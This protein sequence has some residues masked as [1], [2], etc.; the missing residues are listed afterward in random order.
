MCPPCAH[1]CVILGSIPVVTMKGIVLPGE[2]TSIPL[3]CWS[4]PVR[5]IHVAQPPSAVEAVLVDPK[6]ICIKDFHS[7]ASCAKAMEPEGRPWYKGKASTAPRRFLD[8]GGQRGHRKGGDRVYS[9]RQGR[10]EKSEGR[11]DRQRKG[12]RREHEHEHE[13]E[14]AQEV[15]HLSSSGSHRLPQAGLCGLGVLGGE[16]LCSAERIGNDTDAAGA[17][18]C[19]TGDATGRGRGGRTR[20]CP[21]RQRRMPSGSWPAG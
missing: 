2:R 11:S 14:K 3:S 21:S 1:G 5:I 18:T 4:A 10:R 15:A 20:S 7:R 19:G 6:S 8:T 17:R 12:A 13:H 9:E 16:R